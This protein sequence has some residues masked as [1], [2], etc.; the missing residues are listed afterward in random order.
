MFQNHHIKTL[1][2]LSLLILMLTAGCSPRER[3]PSEFPDEEKMAELI[4]DLYIAENVVTRGRSGPPGDPS[5]SNIPGYYKGVLEKYDITVAEFDTIRKWY[6]AHP[7]HYQEVY[8]KAIVKLSRREAELEQ[9][10]REE[11]EKEEAIPEVID[12]W[13]KDRNLTINADDTIDRR[14]PFQ[15]ELDSLTGGEIRFSTMYKFLRE[16]MTKEGEMML[17]I[18][19]RDT[20][21]DT[22]TQKLEKTFQLRN[23]TIETEVDSTMPAT[24]I[25]GLM[26]DHDTTA[27]T[28][29]EF[30]RIRME[31]LPEEIKNKRE[32][33]DTP[34]LERSEMPER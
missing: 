15:I 10:M 2:P 7:Y 27:A 11:R 34:Q 8:D 20:I 13:E 30:S 14:I 3:V 4:A 5:D 22:L 12:L 25:S 1:F 21:A 32:S 18:E 33:E 23:V 17:V 26:F 31:H 29:I 24:S 9:K 6:A 28:A 16:D 19:Y